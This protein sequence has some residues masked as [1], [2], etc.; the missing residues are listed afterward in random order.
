[1]FFQPPAKCSAGQLLLHI[2]GGENLSQLPVPIYTRI[3]FVS[4]GF[5]YAFEQ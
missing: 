4:K 5:S 3:F 2:G 1:M